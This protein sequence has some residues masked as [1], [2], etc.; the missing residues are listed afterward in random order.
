MGTH[1]QG[2]ADEVRALDAYIKLM[3]SVAVLNGNLQQAL[4]AHNLTLSQ[5]GVLES[6][7]HLGP[8][9]QKEVGSKLLLSGGN[10]TTVV[11][12]L[13]KRGLVLRL[14]QANDRRFVRLSL[15][16]PGRELIESVFPE[17]AATITAQLGALT[18]EEQEQ[19]ATLCRKLGRGMAGA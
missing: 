4:R 16:E 17:H 11:N 1:H 19:L 18:C 15:T 9:C 3:R 8:M 14:R 12:N 10:I 13:E 2:C 6:L 7:M 5:L